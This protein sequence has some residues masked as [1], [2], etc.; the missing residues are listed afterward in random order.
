M[1]LTVKLLQSLSTLHNNHIIH[2]DV[3]PQNIMI[4]TKGEYVFID[5]GISKKLK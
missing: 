1:I 3:K 4:N 5:F 2:Q